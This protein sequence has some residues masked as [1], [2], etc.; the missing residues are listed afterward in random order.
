MTRILGVHGI[1]NIRYYTRNQRSASAATDAISAAWARALTEGTDASADLRV[2][3][4]AHQLDRGAAQSAD[5]AALLEDGAQ[6]VLIAWADLL[7]AGAAHAQGGRTARARAAA[8]WLSARYPDLAR[9][10]VLAFCREL[11][12]YQ[13]ARARRDAIIGSLRGALLEHRP[14][15]LVA[16]SLGSVVAYEALWSEPAVE[17]DCLITLGSPLAMPGVVFDRLSPSPDA[18]RGMRPPGVRRWLNFADVGDIVAVP[19]RLSGRFAGVEKD[20]ELSVGDWQFHAVRSYLSTGE[21]RAALREFL[22]PAA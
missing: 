4:Y 22:N 12:T 2:C 9:R 6:D 20:V 21:V 13:S 19:P 8:D 7:N 11:H 16:H 5:D 3:F 1:W 14:E 10:S 15:V 18:G 17:L